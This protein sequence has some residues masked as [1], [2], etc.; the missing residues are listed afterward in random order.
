MLE[1]IKNM[2]AEQKAT[3]DLFKR[4]LVKEYLQV[5]ALSFIYSQSKYRNLIFYGGSALKHCRGIDR[6]SEDLDFVD[7]K[8]AVP[9][10]KLASEL[11]LFFKNQW[12]LKTETKIQKFRIVLKFPVLYELEL[13]DYPQSDLLYLKLEIFKNLS[14]YG[15][16][17]TEVLPLFKYGE[18]VLVKTF[19]LPTMMATKIRAVLHRKW[20]KTSKKG[21]TLAVV[22]GR[23]YYDLM[24]YLQK[25]VKP[26]LDCIEGIK[27]KKD[28]IER[29]IKIR[30]P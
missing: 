1:N 22:K 30:S 23:D 15:K 28:L 16:Y 13:A 7:E 2:L 12:D 27:N 21:E 20:E 5:L 14:F 10:E 19:D 4:N 26:N 6:L 18:S 11:K 25:G 9:F 24:W 17:K 8:G 3:P 29:L